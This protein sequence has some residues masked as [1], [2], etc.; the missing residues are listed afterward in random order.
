MVMKG[1][2]SQERDRHLLLCIPAVPLCPLPKLL[3]FVNLHREPCPCFDY[4]SIVLHQ[5][6]KA[7]QSAQVSEVKTVG[8]RTTWIWILARCIVGIVT[9]EMAK[10]RRCMLSGVLSIGWWSD[11]YSSQYKASERARCAP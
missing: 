6:P 7:V 3:H 4:L 11:T 5:I 1:S 2:N 10:N 8:N 9:V